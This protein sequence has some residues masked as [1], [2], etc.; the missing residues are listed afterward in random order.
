MF[1]WAISE[2]AHHLRFLQSTNVNNLEK[3]LQNF[4]SRGSMLRSKFKTCLTFFD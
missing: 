3:P 4:K 1:G 2:D